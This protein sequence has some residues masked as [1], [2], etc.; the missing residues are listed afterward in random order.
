M[1]R[2]SSQKSACRG[3]TVGL[4]PS[5]RVYG[6]PVPVVI[7]LSTYRL[8]LMASAGRLIGVTG[9]YVVSAEDYLDGIE[10]G[11][12]IEFLTDTLCKSKI[13]LYERMVCLKALC[14]MG[15]LGLAALGRALISLFKLANTLVTSLGTVQCAQAATKG[16]DNTII[17]SNKNTT[18]GGCLP[19]KLALTGR[20]VAVLDVP[21]L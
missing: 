6:I 20:Q 8:K 18:Q 7:L 1:V 5:L 10:N 15:R 12:L 14:I 2:V 21:L 11:S 3:A 4:R 17:D 16:L 13:C 9:T 19:I